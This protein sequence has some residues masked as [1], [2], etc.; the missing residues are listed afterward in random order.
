MVKLV[1]KEYSW[2]WQFKNIYRS[3]SMTLVNNFINT[4]KPDR[5]II[6]TYVKSKS[7]VNWLFIFWKIGSC[8][9]A[10]ALRA[11]DS[12]A[13]LENV[14]TTL[15]TFSIPTPKVLTNFFTKFSVWGV[16][17]AS[18]TVKERNMDLW[19]FTQKQTIKKKVNFSF[20]Q[21]FYSKKDKFMVNV[22]LFDISFL[23]IIK[24]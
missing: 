23:R 2:S 11:N 9:V 20:I 1:N 7:V 8:A 24:C 5:L 6:I 12:D 16:M 15:D 21:H 4:P 13:A 19:S 22:I 3:K 18:A 14:V 17:V 10:C